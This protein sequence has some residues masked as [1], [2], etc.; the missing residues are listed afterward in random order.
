MS[1]KE[2]NTVNKTQHREVYREPAIPTSWEEFSKVVRSRRSVRIYTEMQ[3]SETDVQDCLDM[4]LLAPNSSNLQPWEFIWIRSP[5]LKNQLGPMCFD[6]KAVTTAP[7]IIACVAKTN[8][9]KQ[10]C[11]QML[12]YFEGRNP[13]KSVLL[14]YRKLAPFVYNQGWCGLRGLFK[15]IGFAIVGVSRPVP[16]GPNSNAEMNLWATKS[17]ALACE[18]LMLAF[19]AKGY[20]SCPL[21]GFDESRVKKL[22][23]LD[24]HSS[25]VMMISAG[26][27]AE[28]GIYSE[29]IRFDRS[30]FIRVL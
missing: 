30:Q 18:N 23:K 29:Q 9:W 12:N 14:Y 17:T 15:K 22:L 8:T 28:N 4:A 25:I 5:E 21:E 27:R 6:Q 1:Q 13:P 11:Q 2:D 24:C 3:I 26:Q 10:N 7:V 20:D 19:R 16:R